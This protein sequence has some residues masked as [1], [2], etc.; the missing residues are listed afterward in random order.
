[1]IVAL[2]CNRRRRESLCEENR[3]RADHSAEEPP[4]RLR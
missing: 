1:M 2:D 3:E 4:N